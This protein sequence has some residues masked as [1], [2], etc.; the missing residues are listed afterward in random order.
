MKKITFVSSLLLLILAIS[1]CS[2]PHVVAGEVQDINGNVIQLADYRGKW[3]V[4]NYWASWCEP[5]AKEIPQMN[6]FFQVHQKLD[7]VVLGVNYDNLPPA[8]LRKIVKKMG[9]EYPILAIDPKQ[10]LGIQHVPGLPAT[11]LIS[12]KGILVKSLFGEQTQQGLERA[13]HLAT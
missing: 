3:I 13:M 6:A 5:C 7:A 9:I 2:R 8:E 11:Y 12:P 4:I 1:S 10:L